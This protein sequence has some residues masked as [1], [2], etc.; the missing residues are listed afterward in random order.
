MINSI[1][2][3]VTVVSTLA[4]MMIL[5][6]CAAMIRDVLR[7]VT[8][9]RCTSFS[10]VTRHRPTWT[11]S[12]VQEPSGAWTASGFSRTTSQTRSPRSVSERPS[13][14]P[15]LS[16]CVKFSTTVRPAREPSRGKPWPRFATGWGWI[17]GAPSG[18]PTRFGRPREMIALIVPLAY[19]HLIPT[20]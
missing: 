9:S 14:T 18:E 2:K 15:I 5:S 7:S 6:G 8:S 17:G 3:L 20:G 16:G 11:R 4:L 19:L 13:C 10:P 12:A 1:R